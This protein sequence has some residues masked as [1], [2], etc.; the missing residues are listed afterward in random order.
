MATIIDLTLDEK[1]STGSE[2]VDEKQIGFTAPVDIAVVDAPVTLE[3]SHAAEYV[4]FLQ[5]KEQFEADPKVYSALV[6]KREN[7]FPGRCLWNRIQGMN[8]LTELNS[9]STSALFQCYFCTTF[10]ILSTVSHR[11]AFSTCLYSY[12]NFM[13]SPMRVT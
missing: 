10:S 12:T 5:L 9:Q 8:T 3:P 11:A 2:R 6:R 1:S 7:P 4:E 13:Q